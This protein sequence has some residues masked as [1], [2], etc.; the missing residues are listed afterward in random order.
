MVSYPLNPHLSSELWQY[1][2]KIPILNPEI[3]GNNRNDLELFDVTLPNL[4]FL[5]N[6]LINKDFIRT[7][8]FVKFE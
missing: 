2:N 3:Q 7:K 6:L 8:I 5:K 1:F 4:S